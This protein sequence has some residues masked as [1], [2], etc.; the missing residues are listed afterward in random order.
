MV[1]SSYSTV[2]ES[3]EFRL[4]S[5]T[6]WLC[7]ANVESVPILGSFSKV[8]MRMA[9]SHSWRSP[10]LGSGVLQVGNE[11][12]FPGSILVYPRRMELG[13]DAEGYSTGCVTWTARTGF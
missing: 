11:I 5:W 6:V 7:C 8:Q 3:P 9:S 4:L 10:V 1:T 13:A 12:C 2:L